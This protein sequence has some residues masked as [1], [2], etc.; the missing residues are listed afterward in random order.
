[1]LSAAPLLHQLLEAL[2]AQHL[3]REV[4]GLRLFIAHRDGR[5]QTNEVLL[6]SETWPA[7][8][9]VVAG[10]QAPLPD[11]MVAVRIFGLLVPVDDA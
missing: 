1:V 8:E 4:H 7:G 2:C 9:A 3:P 11:G 6:D 5:L 10:S